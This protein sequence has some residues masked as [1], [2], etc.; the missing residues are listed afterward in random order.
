MKRLTKAQ[1]K[2]AWLTQFSALVVAAVP[3]CAGRID[4]DEAHHFFFT[5]KSPADAAALYVVDRAEVSK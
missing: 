5:G 4:W 2:A 3:S 1:V